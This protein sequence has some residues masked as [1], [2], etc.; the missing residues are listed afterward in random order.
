MEDKNLQD[1]INQSYEVKKSKKK[2]D[3]KILPTVLIIAGIIIAFFVFSNLNKNNNKSLD[4]NT[5]TQDKANDSSDVKDTKKEDEN[6][7]I[8]T[9]DENGKETKY[10]IQE[11]ETSKDEGDGEKS[12][13]D[14]KTSGTVGL[15]KEESKN[16]AKVLNEDVTKTFYEGVDKGLYSKEAV[17]S[18]IGTDREY[19]L[20]N[21]EITQ[22]RNKYYNSNAMLDSEL[23]T[24]FPSEED[25]YTDDYG[26]F[27]ESNY[28]P[29]TLEN[30][31][32]LITHEI[33][34]KINP[35]YIGKKGEAYNISNIYIENY[36]KFNDLGD[37]LNYYKV[38]YLAKSLDGQKEKRDNMLFFI[39]N[40][41]EIVWEKS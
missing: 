17:E 20:I 9:V 21:D 1:K 7:T 25:G 40:G 35:S 8:T 34:K 38:N 26:H 12:K 39:N 23:K 33:E 31:E 29:V 24:Y 22:K 6:Q 36:V 4:N 2:N 11:T 10:K 13:K 28:T 27:G 5:K 32:S 15:V 30:V 3:N 41:G 37:T 14:K 16:R 19:L 18:A